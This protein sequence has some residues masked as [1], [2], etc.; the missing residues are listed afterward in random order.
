MIFFIWKFLQPMFFS[1][2][3]L[4][5]IIRKLPLW[6]LLTKNYYS[7]ADSELYGSE[8]IC[9]TRF[10]Q[11]YFQVV[12]YNSSYMNY[13]ISCCIIFSFL[14][15]FSLT[16]LTKQPLC[17]ANEAT[18]KLWFFSPKVVKFQ[19]YQENGTKLNFF[20]IS[21][22]TMDF[23]RPLVHTAAHISWQLILNWSQ[24]TQCSWYL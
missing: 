10:F 3:W 2:I 18:L 21:I 1:A 9:T 5:L 14:R 20:K 23:K 11:N 22:S 7:N 19:Q 16:S 4:Q 12:N 15:K 24:L 6:Y 8:M 13:F 17:S